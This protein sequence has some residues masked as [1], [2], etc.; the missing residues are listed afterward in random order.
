MRLRRAGTRSTPSQLTDEQGQPITFAT[1]GAPTM[2]ERRRYAQAV[3]RATTPPPLTPDQQAAAAARARHDH[4][5]RE[6][7]IRDLEDSQRR[8]SISAP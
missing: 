3:Q 6:Q 1:P 5:F 4:A 7:R 8:S 2:E